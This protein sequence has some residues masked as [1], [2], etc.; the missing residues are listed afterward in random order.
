MSTNQ[1][2][3]LMLIALMAVVVV[4]YEFIL[5]DTQRLL[6]EAQLRSMSHAQ[7]K[8]LQQAAQLMDALKGTNT[9]QTLEQKF[10]PIYPET[11]A[12]LRRSEEEY[13]FN[14]YL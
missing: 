8:Q 6:R 7:K 9:A 13:R 14:R 2:L 1:I 3:F 10:K 11:D 5:R 4:V 12:E